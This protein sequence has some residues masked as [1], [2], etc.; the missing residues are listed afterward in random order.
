[1]LTQRLDVLNFLLDYDFICVLF[2]ANNTTADFLHHFFAHSVINIQY[3]NSHSGINFISYSL[4]ICLF[5]YLDAQTK[6]FIF[7]ASRVLCIEKL[8]TV[9][10]TNKILCLKSWV[11][12][13]VRYH[14]LIPQC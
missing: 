4:L 7:T 5:C 3:Q 8:C 14:C 2:P 10:V 11:K 13:S 12:K 1:M 9:H 6:V